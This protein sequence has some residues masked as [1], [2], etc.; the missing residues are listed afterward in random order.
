MDSF[1]EQ[2]IKDEEDRLRGLIGIRKKFFDIETDTKTIQQEIRDIEKQGIKT[3]EKRY[4]RLLDD[5]R[6][7]E[8]VRRQTEE[9]VHD[10]AVKNIVNEKDL[11]ID[12]ILKIQAERL[13][14]ESEYQ[15]E[16]EKYISS[17]TRKESALHREKMKDLQ[18][19]IDRLKKLENSERAGKTILT[20]S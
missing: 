1:L 18:S 15:K 8:K 3:D 12:N 9:A 19:E 16:R 10:Q 5:L 2:S 20:V 11:Q 17:G 4:K 13:K 7:V 14:K 6:R